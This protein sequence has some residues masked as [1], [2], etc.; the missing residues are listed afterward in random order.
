MLEENIENIIKSNRNF[1][2]A[3]FDHHVLP[4][5]YFNGCCLIKSNTSIFKKVIQLYISFTLRPQL[6]NLKMLH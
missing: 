4:D 5:I 2:A 6:R 1:A 3:F